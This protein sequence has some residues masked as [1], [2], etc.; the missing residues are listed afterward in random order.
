VRPQP[1]RSVLLTVVGVLIAIAINYLTDQDTAPVVLMPLKRWPVESLLVLTVALII[2]GRSGGRAVGAANAGEQ[3]LQQ[4]A[5]LAA[6]ADRL[7]ARERQHAAAPADLQ[8]RNAE[9]RAT[10]TRLHY[11]NEGKVL[12][13]S[14]SARSGG[15]CGVSGDG[16]ATGSAT[17]SPS[18]R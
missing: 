5:D 2:L 16:T 11:E 12:F 1:Q 15:A 8:K 9:T 17:S 13:T 3:G 7:A 10:R 18:P 14:E 4:A 6:H